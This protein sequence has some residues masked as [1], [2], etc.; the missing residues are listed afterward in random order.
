MLKAC[1][2][3]M[4]QWHGNDTEMPFLCS[5]SYDEWVETT[6]TRKTEDGWSEM[7]KC[8]ELNDKSS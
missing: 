2:D 8:V 6:T 3:T 5:I 1:Y 4:S 7:M